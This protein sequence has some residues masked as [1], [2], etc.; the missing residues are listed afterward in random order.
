MGPAGHFQMGIGQ[1]TVFKEWDPDSEN[2]G[3]VPWQRQVQNAIKYNNIQKGIG[4][5]FQGWGAA[6]CL[7]ANAEYAQMAYCNDVRSSPG[8]S[9]YNCTNLRC[10]E[11][12]NQGP[13]R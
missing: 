11:R 5:D 6:Y 7:C 8:F 12:A 10:I 1:P 3:D 2:R 4:N 9:T 13:T